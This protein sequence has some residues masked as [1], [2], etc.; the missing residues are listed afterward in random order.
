MKIGRMKAGG[1]PLVTLAV[2]GISKPFLEGLIASTPLGNGTVI[3]GAGKLAGA[4]IAR[5]FIGGSQIGN[6]I[7]I[8]L[9]VDAIEDIIQGF[10]RGSVFGGAGARQDYW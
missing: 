9:A 6:G 10:M 1:V 5:Q 3:S 2:A 7:Q 4:M 8:A